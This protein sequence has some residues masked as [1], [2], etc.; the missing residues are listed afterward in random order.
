MHQIAI[1][2]APTTTICLSDHPQ[3]VKELLLIVESATV[4]N[5]A[6]VLECLLSQEFNF[7]GSKLSDTCQLRFFNIVARNYA[8]KVRLLSLCM[9]LMYFFQQ[10]S[11]GTVGN[12]GRE[13][14]FE[15]PFSC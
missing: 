14:H 8:I 4:E 12:F 7:L 3:L 13:G 15:Y 1:L 9:L 6:A 2:Y 5:S 10:T 11:M